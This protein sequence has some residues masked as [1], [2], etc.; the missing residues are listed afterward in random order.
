[1]TAVGN[2]GS[3]EPKGKSAAA[4]RG[5]TRG[6]RFGG[7]KSSASTSSEERIESDSWFHRDFSIRGG[8]GQSVRNLFG[9]GRG[10]MIESL[11]GPTDHSFSDMVK[12][13]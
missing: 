4:D 12:E 11:L 1:M 7:L 5:E 6:V 13:K 9:G 8:F 3:L 10:S 2:Y